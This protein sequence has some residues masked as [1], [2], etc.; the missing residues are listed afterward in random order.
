MRTVYFTYQRVLWQGGHTAHATQDEA[1]AETEQMLD[2]ACR[3]TER[4][5]LA[6]IYQRAQNS[7]ERF[8]GALDTYCIEA[9]MQGCKALQEAEHPALLRRFHVEAFDVE[10]ANKEISWIMFG[11]LHGGGVSTRLISCINYVAL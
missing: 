1:I 7:N 4:N 10:T 11:Q 6:C 5:W 3:F 9:L 8:A 2:S